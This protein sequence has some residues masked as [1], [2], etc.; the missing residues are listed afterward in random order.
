MNPNI[1]TG[2]HRGG[3]PMLR[4][5]Q[6]TQKTRI[7]RVKQL[8]PNAPKMSS[9]RLCEAKFPNPIWE[10]KSVCV[11]TCPVCRDNM[12]GKRGLSR[13][14]KNQLQRAQAIIES[15]SESAPQTP[16]VDTGAFKSLRSFGD[17]E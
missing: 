10:G 4:E 6:E 15:R 12:L 17:V 5:M 1:S 7:K 14:K 2:A 16:T 13:I 8:F 9:C 3:D 11:V